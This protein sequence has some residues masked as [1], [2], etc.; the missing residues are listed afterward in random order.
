M[1]RYSDGTEVCVGDKVRHATAE[2][3]VETVIENEDVA[4]WD[5]EVPG[6][7][8]LCDQFGPIQLGTIPPLA[9]WTVA[10]LAIRLR[11]PR[12]ALRRCLREPGMVGCCAATAGILINVFYV[13]AL[14]LAYS[15]APAVTFFYKG[16]DVRVYAMEVGFTVIG[17]WVGLILVRGW[18]PIPCWIDRLG[19]ALSLLW[20]SM[21]GVYLATYLIHAFSKYWLMGGA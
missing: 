19:R 5:L 9:A 15:P 18:R 13:L 21:I 12:P 20:V 6:F 2:A 7:M 17:T 11:R 8:L 4:R 1:L 14:A 10:F 16:N 3:V